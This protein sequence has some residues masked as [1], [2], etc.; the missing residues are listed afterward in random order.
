MLPPGF[1]IKGGMGM[2]DGYQLERP[3]PRFF[4]G[5]FT[6]FSVRGAEHRTHTNA[7]SQRRPRDQAGGVSMV[8]STPNRKHRYE[9]WD[10]TN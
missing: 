9:T 7:T 4:C 10:G 6:T 8:A 1:G 2:R 5:Q 3:P